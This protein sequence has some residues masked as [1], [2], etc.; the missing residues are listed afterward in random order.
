MKGKPSLA[1]SG[2]ASG[3]TLIEVLIVVAI[4]AILAAIALPSYQDYVLRGKLTEGT[5]ELA[6]MRAKMEQYY[7]DNRTYAAA[8]AYTPPCSTASKAGLFS[9]SCTGA[10][11]AL[12]ATAYTLVAQG[13]GMA[14]DFIYTID[15]TG[16]KGTSSTKWPAPANKSDTCWLMKPSESC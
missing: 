3:F 4:V 12:S 11:S 8:G 1:G 7:Q 15:E 6:A 14:A 13:S 10:G 2:R 5:N 16:T 9:V